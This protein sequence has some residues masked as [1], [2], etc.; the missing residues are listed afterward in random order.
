MKFERGQLVRRVVYPRPGKKELHISIVLRP[1]GHV[2]T[3]ALY[4]VYDT[5]DKVAYYSATWN[6]ETMNEV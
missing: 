5:V 6:L 2:A 3:G 1:V 4:E